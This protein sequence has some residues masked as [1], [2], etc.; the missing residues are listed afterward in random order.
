MSEPKKEAGYFKITLGV[1]VV[2]IFLYSQGAFDKILEKDEEP[3]DITSGY[4]LKVDSIVL[5]LGGKHPNVAQLS[6]AST[7]R[8]DENGRKWLQDFEDES[9]SLNPVCLFDAVAYNKL[10]EQETFAHIR[11]DATIINGKLNCDIG[12]WEFFGDR[13]NEYFIEPR[14]QWDF[15]VHPEDQFSNI[16]VAPNQ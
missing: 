5:H 12:A 9:K 15:S 4:S 13:F 10:T 8:I 7:D 14:I 1:I 3:L 6:G 16:G 11:G 2:I